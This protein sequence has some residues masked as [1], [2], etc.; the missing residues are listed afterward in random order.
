MNLDALGNIGEAVSSFAVIVSLVYLAFQ[1]RQNTKSIQSQNHGRAL[2]RISSIQSQMAQDSNFG[3]VYAAAVEDVTELTPGQRI[4][5]TWAF[6][7]TF[8]AFEFM[9]HAAK[10]G[11][12]PD[13]VWTRWQAICAWWLTFPGIQAI[14]KARPTPFTASFTAFVDGLL[15][16]NP[17]DPEMR[18]RYNDFVRG[19]QVEAKSG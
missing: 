10:D 11:V 4:Q 16:N 2:D 13:E 19:D 7:E 5:F 18:Q 9:Y 12:I 8:G 15:E 17:A 14:W 6:Y 1:M 3:R